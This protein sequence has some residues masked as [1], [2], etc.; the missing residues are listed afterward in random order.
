MGKVREELVEEDLGI[1]FVKVLR[2]GSVVLDIK[3]FLRMA[4]GAPL[5]GLNETY[6][7]L[8]RILGAV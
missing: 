7:D 3:T 8:V 1:D 4:L 5:L 2:I 6:P